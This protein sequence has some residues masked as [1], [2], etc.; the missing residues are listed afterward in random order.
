MGVRRGGRD[1]VNR[2]VPPPIEARPR[3]GKLQELDVV[4]LLRLLP[5]DNGACLR[6]GPGLDA[7]VDQRGNADLVDAWLARALR[8]SFL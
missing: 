4:S 3:L 6:R 8:I 1:G 5:L 2:V 7:E